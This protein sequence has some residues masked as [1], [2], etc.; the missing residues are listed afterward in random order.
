MYSNLKDM[1]APTAESQERFQLIPLLKS[2]ASNLRYQR[3]I[4]ELLNSFVF[5]RKLEGMK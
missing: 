3:V 4:L 2:A 5:T 1:F